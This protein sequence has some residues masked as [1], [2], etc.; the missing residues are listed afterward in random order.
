MKK[1][2]IV[3]L[4]LAEAIPVLSQQNTIENPKKQVTEGSW[5]KESPQ[6]GNYGIDL[7]GAQQILKGK[8][9][10]KTPII[11]LIGTGA[12]IEHEALKNS[13]W[14]NPNEKLDGIDNDQNGYIDDINGW[15]FIGYNNGQIMEKTLNE[16]DREWARLKDKYADLYFDGKNY[17]TIENGIRKSTSKPTNLSEFTYFENL[18]KV[19]PIGLASKYASY[20]SAFLLKE[21]VATWDKQIMNKWKGKTRME[22]PAD[23]ALESIYDKTK[24]LEMDSIKK[25]TITLISIYSQL[26]KSSKQDKNYSTSWEVIYDNFM[27]KQ[28]AFAKKIFDD[29][30][31]LIGEDKRQS[32]LKDDPNNISDNKYGNNT[33]LTAS[34]GFGTLISGLIVGND[35]NG[36][37]FSGIVPDAKIM[38]L[39]I[40]A[41]S[42]DPYPKDM[43]LAIKYAVN[44]GADVIVLP[45]QNTLFSTTQKTWIYDAIRQAEK[46]GVLV[47]VPALE[48]RE[49]LDQIKYYPRRENFNGLPFT[50]LMVIANSD[51]KGLPSE[52]SSYGKNNLDMFVPGVTVYS[53][54]P[55][56]AYNI[57]NSPS[58]CVAIAAG[59]AALIKSY[60][61]NLTGSQ[62]RS[63]LMANVTS[64]KGIEIE[65]SF[66][67]KGKA[68]LDLFLFEQLCTSAGILNLKKTVEAASKIK[69]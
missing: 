49:D 60:F 63:L 35:V 15:N 31:R 21:F 56:H 51:K 67:I 29:N 38:N 18:R 47:I 27:N 23:S 22:I 4:L 66:N 44:N 41:K 55:G 7:I 69:K 17:F 46:K 3:I 25:S 68:V 45:Q 33:L 65:K 1:I 11:A 48:R 9:K 5:Y 28:I 59:S 34:S 64:R 14:I 2:L 12:D 32:L 58:S 37:G 42:G 52:L 54:L 50:N 61:P 43:A 53:T 24:P 40:T 39:V 30:Y 26:Y 36:T 10:L 8:K 6:S 62:I 20:K 57:V 16:A 19:S 13:V